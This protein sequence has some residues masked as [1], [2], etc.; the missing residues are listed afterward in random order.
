MH[1]LKKQ[2]LFQIIFSEKA[3]SSLFLGAQRFA[4]RLKWGITGAAPP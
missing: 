4:L 1:Q 3:G 2:I